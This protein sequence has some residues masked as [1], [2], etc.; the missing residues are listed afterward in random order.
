MKLLRL[1]LRIAG[2]VILLLILGAAF[3]AFWPLSGKSIIFHPSPVADYDTARAEFTRIVSEEP[4]DVLPRCRTF[5]LD[6]GHRTKNVYVL[7]HGLTNCPQQFRALGE[8]LFQ[9]GANVLVPR[10]PYQGLE[11]VL[12]DE[13]RLLD[14]QMMIDTSSRAVDLAR[15]YGDHVI[16]VGLSIN[17]TSAAWLAQERDDIDLAVVMA[18]F[19]VPYGVPSWCTAPITRTFLRLP[20]VFMWWDPKLKDA[21]RGTTLT[22]PRF[23]T[24]PIAETMWLGLDVFDRAEKSAPQAK[25]ILVITSA[26]DTAVSNVRTAE[27]VDIWENSAPDRV[28]TYQFP[29]DEHVPH[30][31]IDPG[32]ANQEVALVYPILIEQI[33]AA[34]P[35]E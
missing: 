2:I 34:L 5:A 11:N 19:F 21:Q 30:D 14:A 28:K 23:A 24:R 12:N 26:F 8:L 22:Y 6:H 13:Q 32:Q 3:L 7:L 31:F 4:A 33:K 16:V 20:N 17:G 15:G 27:L 29:V 1:I 9:Q 35:A 18:P 25:S 10:L